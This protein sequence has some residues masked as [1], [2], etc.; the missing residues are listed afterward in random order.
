M[1]SI[2]H[3]LS[4]EGTFKLS[5]I[6]S[7]Q[8]KVFV[9]S[10]HLKHVAYIVASCC[11]VAEPPSIESRDLPCPCW[12]MM[13]QLQL[14]SQTPENCPAY[15]LSCTR[16]GHTTSPLPLLIPFCTPCFPQHRCQCHKCP[17]S[18]LY[19]HPSLRVPA[20]NNFSNNPFLSPHYM[21]PASTYQPEATP[22]PPVLLPSTRYLLS[23][24]ED[25]LMVKLRAPYW[26]I[27]HLELVTYITEGSRTSVVMCVKI[28]TC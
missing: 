15:S 11:L 6:L 23:W 9:K 17:H 3:W 16:E 14:L 13:T 12:G 8:Q 4:S 2:Q 18:L 22:A 1:V 5:T 10:V 20:S 21:Q 7:T 19:T 25:R 24:V 26:N 27:L 28:D